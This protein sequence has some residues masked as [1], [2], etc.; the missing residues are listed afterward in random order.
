MSQ[1]LFNYPITNFGNYQ[2]FSFAWLDCT[3]S[4]PDD[5]FKGLAYALNLALWRN[6]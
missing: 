4:L 3:V 1:E 5:N 6:R 2:I